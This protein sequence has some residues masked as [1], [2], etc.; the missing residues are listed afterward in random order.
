MFSNWNPHA[1]VY[2]FLSNK[3]NKNH[4][5]VDLVNYLVNTD[6]IMQCIFDFSSPELCSLKA[7]SM[8]T[9]NDDRNVPIEIKVS[10]LYSISFNVHPY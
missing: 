2:D 3:Y 8:L 5:L 4:D 10:L 1:F 6:R 7:Y 9:D